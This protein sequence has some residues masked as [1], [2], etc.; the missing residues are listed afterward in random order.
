MSW[1]CPKCFRANNDHYATCRGCGDSNPAGATAGSKPFS[2]PS[3]RTPAPRGTAGATTSPS[4]APNTAG[5]GGPSGSSGFSSGMPKLFAWAR[6]RSEIEGDVMSLN[7]SMIPKVGDPYRTMSL[8]I[9]V[10]LFGFAA[11][12]AAIGLVAGLILIGMMLSFM[13]LGSKLGMGGCSPFLLHMMMLRG[14]RGSQ[15]Q[16]PRLGIRLRD[17]TG[18]VFDTVVIGHVEW[19]APAVGDRLLVMGS[20]RGGVLQIAGG[21]NLTTGTEIKVS[22][23]KWRVVF[24]I[25]IGLLTVAVVGFALSYLP[26]EGSLR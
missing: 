1:N 11:L 12:P 15:D 6:G 19:P 4:P 25:L 20:T 18:R 17:D 2:G 14:V 22:V 9:L 13:G 5:R 10:A 7:E 21:Q 8:V 24:L 26:G 16:V 3:S 23:S